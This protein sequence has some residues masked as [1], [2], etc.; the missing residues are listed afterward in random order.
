MGKKTGHAQKEET[1]KQN[2]QYEIKNKINKIKEH[3]FKLNRVV[4][5]NN[6]K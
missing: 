5:S 1:M 4:N 3:K 2:V 6:N